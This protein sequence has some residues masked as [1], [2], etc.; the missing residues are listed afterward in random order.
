MNPLVVPWK[1]EQHNDL[2]AGAIIHLL[3]PE[4]FKELWDGAIVYNIFGK[5]CV[6]GTDEIDLDTRFGRLAY[7]ILAK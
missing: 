1:I 5:K 4:D 2:Q 6:K 7:G 3:T